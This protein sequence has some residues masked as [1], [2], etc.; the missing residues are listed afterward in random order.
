MAGSGKLADLVDAGAD[1]RTS[2]CAQHQPTVSAATTRIAAI[3]STV[4]GAPRALARS[5]VPLALR[6]TERENSGEG[7]STQFEMPD[8][9]T[10]VSVSFGVAL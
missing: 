10:I 7:L 8:G 9:C 2:A 6:H 4:A 5:S 3:A 1:G